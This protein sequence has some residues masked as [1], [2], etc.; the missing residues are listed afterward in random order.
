MTRKGI[1]EC[2]CPE[3]TVCDDTGVV[4]IVSLTPKLAIN[5]LL[6]EA[7]CL[8][9]IDIYKNHEANLVIYLQYEVV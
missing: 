8:L 6:I 3:I 1:G 5:I 7:E 9:V 4:L 2:S